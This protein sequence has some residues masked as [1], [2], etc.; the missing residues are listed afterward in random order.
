MWP[1]V[2]VVEGIVIGVGVAWFCWRSR[3]ALRWASALL[4]RALSFWRAGQ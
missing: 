2:H 3:L 4:S 1:L